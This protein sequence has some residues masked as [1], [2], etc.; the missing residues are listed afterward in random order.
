MRKTINWSI[1]GTL[2]FLALFMVARYVGWSGKAA[3]LNFNNLAAFAVP[4][5]LLALYVLSLILSRDGDSGSRT[6]RKL[7]GATLLL[8][9]AGFILV[10]TI[11]IGMFFI[12]MTQNFVF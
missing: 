12:L 6:L 5:L 8:F 3:G 4:A 11:L 10:G 1:L 2:G 7:T 9:I